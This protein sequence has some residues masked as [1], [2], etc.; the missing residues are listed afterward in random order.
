MFYYADIFPSQHHMR[1][2]FVP[3]TDLLPK[4]S[5]A[6]KREAVARIVD[7]D[8]IMAFDHDIDAPL[9]KFVSDGKKLITHPVNEKTGETLS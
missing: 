4:D 6:V 3:A 1:V 5:M 7:Q 8:V 2:P 9:A